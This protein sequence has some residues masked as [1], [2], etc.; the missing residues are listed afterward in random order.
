MFAEVLAD[1]HLLVPDR[2][3]PINEQVFRSLHPGAADDEIAALEVAEI[4]IVRASDGAVVVLQA[5]VKHHSLF[6]GSGRVLDTRAAVENHLHI[7]AESAEITR[8]TNSNH[9]PVIYAV[10]QTGGSSDEHYLHSFSEECAAAA[11]MRSADRKS[12]V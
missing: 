10:I 5:G 1:F 3:E 12:V 4:E 9:E 2:T 6:L 11:Y 8:M 7:G